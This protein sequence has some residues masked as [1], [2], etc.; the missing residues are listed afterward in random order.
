MH[1]NTLPQ[2][3]SIW[4]QLSG[5]VG[6]L[7]LVFAAA[8]IGA[9]AS[10]NAPTFYAALDL[11]PW[12]PPGWLFGPVWSLLYGMMAISAFLVWRRHGFANARAALWLFIVQLGLNAL[13]T[14]LFFYWRLGAFAFVEIVLLLLWL[15]ATIVA[16]WKLGSKLAAILLLPY[17]AWVSFATLLTWSVWQRNPAMLG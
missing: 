9:L 5:F 13:W 10:F 4:F 11:P 1:M 2:Y 14:P 6:W 15:V 12:A 16:F 8:A 3:R 7:V 17:L